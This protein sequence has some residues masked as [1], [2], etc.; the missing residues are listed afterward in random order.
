MRKGD[1]KSMGAAVFDIGELLGARGGT[2]GKKLKG[3]GTL[4][5]QVRRSEGSGV[6]RMKMKGVKLT[7][8]EGFLRKSDPFYE[9]SRKVNAAGGQTWDNVF[10]SETVKDNLSPDWK[11]MSIEISVLCGG[12]LDLPILVKVYDYESKGGH[13]LMGQFETSANGLVSSACSNS[14]IKMKKKGKDTGSIFIT[15]AAVSGVQAPLEQKVATMSVA[16]APASTR[17]PASTPATSTTTYKQQPNFVDYISGGT[18]LNVTVAI[19]FT[20]SNGDPRKPGTLHHIRKDGELN[21][22]EKAIKS[23]LGVL[24]KFD[25]DKKFPVLGFG[26]KYGGVVRHAF[27]CGAREEVDGIDGVLQAYR[28]VFKSGLVMSRPTVINEVIQFAANRAEASLEDAFESGGQTYSILLILTDGAVS[29]VASTASCLELVN[30]APLS[31]VIVGVGNADFT[32]MK[33]L[34]DL[35]KPGQRDIV[36]FVP[37]NN[38]RNNPSDLSSATLREIPDQ[39]VGYFQKHGIEPGTAIRATEAQ[40]IVEEEEEID[41]TLDIGEDEIVVSAGGGNFNNW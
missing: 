32:G 38:Y 40:I 10:R 20:G 13:V 29:D 12:D 28:G 33:F 31:I 41:L 2:K 22:Y 8:T 26:A 21:D 6:L 16:P 9:L 34:D 35:R 24:A 5:A 18:Q 7:N 19:D 3:Q 14:E 37:F 17:V 15:K 4:Y 1:N 25:H 23:I 27:Q 39:M 11:E 36:Q 30:D